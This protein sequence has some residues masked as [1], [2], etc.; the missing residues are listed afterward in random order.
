MFLVTTRANAAIL[1]AS[2]PVSNLGTEPAII[3]APAHALDDIVT[4][5]GMQGF[6]E[7]QGVLTAV[8]YGTDGG[9]IP[10]GTPVDSHM[11]F[12]NSPGG[13]LL[14]HYAVV[15]TFSGPIVGVMSDNG[16][17]L[18]AKS[19]SELGNPAT[20]YTETFDDSGPAAPFNNRGFE[21]SQDWCTI[22]TPNSLEVNMLVTEPGD[23]IRVIT[24][25]Q[26][27]GTLAVSGLACVQLAG[28]TQPELE[29][30]YP[31]QL[32]VPPYYGDTL[33]SA[34]TLPPCVAVCGRGKLSISAQGLWSHTP[35][36]AEYGTGPDGYGA[37]SY[38][39]SEYMDLGGISEA[40]AP[41]NTLVG[42]FLTNDLP[43]PDPTARPPSLE[44]GVHSMTSPEL[45][46]AFAIGSGLVDV[47]IPV[48]ATRLFL[49]LKN[50]YEWINNS[51]QVFVDVTHDCCPVKLISLTAD[52]V[53]VPV[54]ASVMFEGA[55]TDGCGEVYAHWD[56][57]DG[58]WD[59]Q[60]PATSPTIQ[61]HTY[62]A[63]GVYEVSLTVDDDLG[64]TD[65]E[66]VM[67]VAY[68]PSA[69]FVT[70]GGWIDSP[71][72]AY[73]PDSSLGGKASF[74]FVS[75][76]KKGATVPTGNTEFQFKAADLN[77]HS[78]SYNWLV[79]TQGGSRAQFKGTGTINGA[80]S[81]RFM[82]WAGDSAPDT[83]RIR[84]W[85]EDDLGNETDVYD[86]GFDGSGYENGQP[87][88]GGSIVIHTK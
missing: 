43:D 67:V 11:I 86:N 1:S 8:A 62:T 60:G 50:G 24:L 79:V 69:G 25:A 58:I 63:S 47:R 34:G 59:V 71:E 28:Q 46:Q 33:E 27:A 87:I 17:Y 39:H 65:G 49:G 31:S 85:T 38:T 48:G 30:A 51:G 81:Y 2:G 78:S 9:S 70:G 44:L 26:P 6:D 16:G 61:T 19:T 3:A 20:N 56:F 37:N 21:D 72:G 77:F 7:A 13:T 76:Y 66:T 80:G 73:I 68:D 41:R 55:F 53:L 52:P 23:W 10:I 54:G 32:Y 5:T 64:N 35:Y 75:K 57:G 15:W 4:N 74:G 36:L 45:Q 83:F 14:S 84:I 42:V 40:I 18:E 29:A 82:L 22:L 88:G 12:L